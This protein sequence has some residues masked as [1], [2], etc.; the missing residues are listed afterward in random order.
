MRSR[1]SRAAGSD[2]FNADLEV[3][4]GGIHGRAD[5]RRGNLLDHG[6]ILGILGRFGAGQLVGQ[7]AAIL[8]GAA[9]EEPRAAETWLALLGAGYV[10]MAAIGFFTMRGRPW[11]A[12]F[13]EIKKAVLVPARELQSRI[14]P[15][16]DRDPFRAARF[17]FVC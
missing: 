12:R 7:Q 16:G 11:P 17:W 13:C 1:I 6:E 3:G 10:L 14:G 9:V 4:L 5:G 15:D 8:G 2:P